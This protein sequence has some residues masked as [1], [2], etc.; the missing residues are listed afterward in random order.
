MVA[1]PNYSGP[2]KPIAPT[3]IFK[4]A[5]TAA[6]R[7]QDL[8]AG[9]VDGIDNVGPD[10]FATV[11]GDS[12]LQLLKRDAFSTL[13]LGFNIDDAPWNNEAVRQAIAMG[14]DRKRIVDLFYPPGSTVADYF[15]PCS[16]PG[17]CEGD[18]W[19][20]FNKDAAIAA[21]KAAN[22]DFSK[23][24]D[25]LLPP[26][27][28]RLLPEPAGHRDRDPGA[29]QGPRDQHQDPHRGQRHLPHQLEQG[30]VLAVPARLGR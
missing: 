1:N 11:Q 23:T 7:L 24:Y 19:Y 5:D 15:T 9:T 6:K 26:E 29:V 28:P 14:I 25:L 2:N 30:P 20:A 3:L 18:A 17:G 12:S 13:Y 27:G 22:F 4:W 10:D 8:Q 16:V 21:L